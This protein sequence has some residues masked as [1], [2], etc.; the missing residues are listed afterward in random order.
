MDDEEKPKL[1]DTRPDFSGKDERTPEG[2]NLLKGNGTK[3]GQGQDSN[4]K[5][6]QKS[7]QK[8]GAQEKAAAGLKAAEAAASKNPTAA[9]SAAG[10]EKSPAS[11]FTGSGGNNAKA[12]GLKSIG[13]FMQ[14]FGPIIIVGLFLMVFLL[15][16]IVLVGVPILLIGTIDY[17]LQKQLGWSPMSALLRSQAFTVIA[18]R[19]ADGDFPSEL[20]DDFASAGIIVGQTTASG[21]FIKTNQ[22]IADIDALTDVAA[23]S[24]F[25]RHGDSGSLSIM[26]NG[27]VISADDFVAAVDTNPHLYVAVSESMDIEAR[28]YY[29]NEVNN[30]YKDLGVSRNNFKDFK[31]TSDHDTDQENFYAMLDKALVNNSSTKIEGKYE[32]SKEVE[33]TEEEIKAEREQRLADGEKEPLDIP[34]TK[35]VTEDNSGEVYVAVGTSESATEIVSKVASMTKGSEA[36]GKAAQLLNS[37][38]SSNE[39]RQAAS[40]FVAMESVIQEARAEGDGPV[41][42]AMNAM[43][44]E[45]EVS[46]TDVATG[47]EKIAKKSILNTDNFVA[48]VS[49]SNNFSTDEALN[50]SR[51]RAIVATSADASLSKTTAVG[52][53]GGS[54]SQAARKKKKL[55]DEDGDVGEGIY[56]TVGSIDMSITPIDNTRFTSVIG[57][58]RIIEGGSYLSGTIGQ[59]TIGAM[60]SDAVTIMAYKQTTDTLLAKEAAAE[61]AVLSPFDISSPNTLLGSLVH[62]FAT[63]ILGA[64]NG[65]INP[66]TIASATTSVAKKSVDNL[67]GTVTAASIDDAFITYNGNCHTT[68]Q[69]ANVEGDLYCNSHNTIVSKY[70]G[71]TMSE[72]MG[73]LGVSEN[74]QPTLDGHKHFVMLGMERASTF[75]VQSA[76]V[77]QTYKNLENSGSF[78]KRV[79]SFIGDFFALTDACDGIDDEGIYTGAKYALSASNGDVHNVELYAGYALYDTVKSVL[80]GVQ[81]GI[82][83]FKDEYYAMYP[84]DTSPAG[85]LAEISGMTKEQAEYTLALISYNNYIA[86]YNPAERYAFGVPAVEM[87]TPIFF[88]SD[89]RVAAAEAV[90][91]KEIAYY[92]LR[93]R[94]FVV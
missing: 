60:P 47:E 22:Y 77:C 18:E 57:G 64:S 19:M 62:N 5:S 81:S 94:N 17:N 33:R 29:S 80:T 88:E 25:E 65:K 74:G 32:T 36:T 93:N 51:D 38:I 56:T 27:E 70:I 53:S 30:V 46:Y 24:D 13:D 58:N 85:R 72:W 87:E 82:S 43:S 73:A 68:K 75:G 31:I 16:I 9:A 11:L 48:V 8:S 35:T 6:D 55:K 10:G 42:F 49:E 90:L 1:F 86:N 34:T 12:S 79:I 4:Q 23:K 66:V 52:S 61:R 44:R 63:T 2:V 40:A 59:R 45:S 54:N 20:A 76:A 83:R 21:D 84:K 15:P 41:N 50:F 3:E 67:F 7:N 14:K 37:A 89:I 69:A 91:I 39:P 26:F 71:N 28:F 78:F 92:D